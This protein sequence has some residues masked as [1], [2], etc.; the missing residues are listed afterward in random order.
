MSK[1]NPSCTAEF[2]L[3]HGDPPL[4]DTFLLTPLSD[5]AR[6]WCDKYF[7]RDHPRR[8][9]PYAADTKRLGLAYAIQRSQVIA[10]CDAI[11]ADGFYI[12]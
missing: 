2:T 12:G 10:L 7:D 11:T 6:A 5:D 1:R 4:G 9:L 3:L 8:P